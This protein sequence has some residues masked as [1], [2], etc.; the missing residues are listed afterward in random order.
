MLSSVAALARGGTNIMGTLSAL[1]AVTAPAPFMILRRPASGP[2][3]LVSD[4]S[5]RVLSFFDIRHRIFS[6]GECPKT[7][8]FWKRLLWPVLGAACLE[9][10]TVEKTRIYSDA[11]FSRRSRTFGGSI[12]RQVRW[13]H[14]IGV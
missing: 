11:E 7:I 14:R 3:T 1:A 2:A 9:I 5:E 8:F 12:T 6:E 4:F 13:E 10:I